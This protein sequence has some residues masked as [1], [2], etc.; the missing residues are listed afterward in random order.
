MT[1]SHS[2]RAKS[3]AKPAKPYPS[4]PLYAHARGRW[5]KKHKGKVYYFGRWDDP[6][7]ALREFDQ[8]RVNL[9]AGNGDTS[10][11]TVADVVNDFLAAKQSKA[12][13]GEISDRTFDTLHRTGKYIAEFFGRSRLVGSLKPRDF[14]AMRADIAKRRNPIGVGN[15]VTRVK[16]F[17]KWA[18]ESEIINPISFGPEFKRPQQ[19]VIRRHKQ[20]NTR[21]IFTAGELRKII[22]A[23]DVH[24]RAMVLLAL[25]AGMNNGDIADFRL[26]SID[27]ETGWVD[28]PR[29]KTA[30]PRKFALWPETKRALKES[31]SARPTPITRPA[32]D[33]FFVRPSGQAWDE[34]NRYDNLVTRAFTRLLRKLKLDR[35]GQSFYLLRHNFSDWAQE[36]GDNDA[37]DVLM[38]HANESIRLN[39]RHHFPDARLIKVTNHVRNRVFGGGG[40]K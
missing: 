32:R 20:Q 31:L 1:T 23:A 39:Y 6:Q 34:S 36:L 8:W 2:T 18:A 28:F 17:F 12:I 35:D 25:N 15:E 37:V 29:K 7:A 9:E 14:T 3:R 24:M 27:W 4:F 11:A 33:R 40:A 16:Q 38:G 10:G 22:K 13:T 26:K 19:N 5:A 21:E 30:V